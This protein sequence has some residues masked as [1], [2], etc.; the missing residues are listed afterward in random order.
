MF[1]CYHSKTNTDKL[2]PSVPDV[3]ERVSADIARLAGWGYGLIKQDFTTWDITGRWGSEMTTGI[4]AGGWAFADSTRTTAEIIT[5]LYTAIQDAAGDAQIIGCNTVGHLSAGLF[6]LQR[7]G[8]DTSGK[9]WERTRKMGVNSLAF[10]LPQH[11]T[12]WAADADC[13][14]L[15]PDISWEENRQWLDVLAR[16]G[17]ALFVSADPA[18]VGP[19]Q[20][21]AL[22]DAFAVAARPVPPAEPVDWLDTTCPRVWR[23]GDKEVTYDWHPFPGS[24][25][26]CPP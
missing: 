15:R 2:D 9:H 12:F 10:R 1:H 26:S 20:K 24:A 13:V 11:G 18:A 19:A 6:A 17:T 16:S 7:T 21:A 3:L 5:S 22:R 4:T 14:G 25:F 23:F 8:D